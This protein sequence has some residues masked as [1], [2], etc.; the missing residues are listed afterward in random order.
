M[1][2][3]QLHGLGESMGVRVGLVSY[4]LGI[5]LSVTLMLNRME[6]QK[7]ENGIHVEPYMRKTAFLSIF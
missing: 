5:L 6:N 7:A 4:F 3:E 1:T 2:E